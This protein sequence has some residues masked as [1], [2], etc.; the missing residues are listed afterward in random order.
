MAQPNFTGI[1]CMTRWQAV[2]GALSLAWMAGP[3]AVCAA[4]DVDRGRYLVENVMA[5]GNC[6]T[7]KDS[8]ARPL[9]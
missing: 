4:G 2:S 6:H 9:R 5:C 3:F 7:A 1:V 8:E